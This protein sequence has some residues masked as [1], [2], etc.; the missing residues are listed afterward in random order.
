MNGE[1]SSNFVIL[2]LQ[3]AEA[4]LALDLVCRFRRVEGSR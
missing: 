4:G 2:A 1:R 3:I